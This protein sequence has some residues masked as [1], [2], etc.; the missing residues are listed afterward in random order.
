MVSLLFWY[1]SIYII[2]VSVQVCHLAHPV[3]DAN[4]ASFLA[5]TVIVPQNI[6]LH[7]VKVAVW[8][9]EVDSAVHQDTPVRGG[10]HTVSLLLR[11]PP[12]TLHTN[13]GSCACRKATD[14]G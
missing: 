14:L 1:G 3:C 4:R 9:S 12:S 6:G 7:A 11:L 8:C 13:G 5:Y 2:P 10:Q